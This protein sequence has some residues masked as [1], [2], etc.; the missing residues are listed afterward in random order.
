[1]QDF[2]ET[3]VTLGKLQFRTIAVGDPNKPLMLF[4][5]GFPDC[6]DGWKKHMQ[7]FSATHYCVA[8][9]QRG[10]NGSSAPKGLHA[11]HFDELAKDVVGMIAYVGKKKATL[12]GH[13]CG[14]VVAYHTAE[15]YPERVEKLII[16]N[17]SHL[18]AWKMFLL[19]SP[20]QLCKSY[21]IFLF[22]IP[23][24]PEFMLR[25]R[26]F[27]MLR[28][29]G[30][31]ANGEPVGTER[32]CAMWKRSSLTGMINWY[33]NAFL[34]FWRKKIT[35]IPVLLLYSKIDKFFDKKL[36]KQ[37]VKIFPNTTVELVPFGHHWVQHEFPKEFCG[38]IDKWMATEASH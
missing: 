29:S 11:Y 10:Y 37:N 26:N 16:C 18:H 36:W 9:D 12:V 32:Y 33:R 31:P 19:R 38:Y 24:L 7:H 6:A 20:V 8:Y 30:N 17:S 25:A 15:R 34:V 22:H 1:M 27:W 5:H 35:M 21:Y 13:D 23:W 3:Q 14:G 28:T 4:L 2:V